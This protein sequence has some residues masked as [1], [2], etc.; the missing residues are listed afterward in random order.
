MAQQWHR[1]LYQGIDLPV[2]YYAGEIRDTDQRFPELFGYEV[3]VGVLPDILRRSVSR[4]TGC[5]RWQ[6]T[7]FYL[8]L[9]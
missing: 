3:Q 6:Y 5:R 4:I 1:D 8:Q 9:Q 2:A 7:N